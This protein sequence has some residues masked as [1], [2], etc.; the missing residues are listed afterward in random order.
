MTETEET[1]KVEVTHQRM[2]ASSINNVMREVT[3]VQKDGQVAFGKT[4]YKYA[5]E[6]G[7]LAA[8]RPAMVKHGLV[9][10]PSCEEIKESGSKVYVR[11]SY[12]LAHTSG[13]VWHEKLSMWGCGMD[14][15]DKAIYKAETGANKYML[16]KLFSIPTGDDP[17]AGKQPEEQAAKPAEKQYVM[18]DKDYVLKDIMLQFPGASDAAR[19][20]R[21]SALNAELLGINIDPVDSPDKVSKESWA[22]IASKLKG[23]K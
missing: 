7:F 20:N 8:L 6:A 3:H 23:S 12:T 16:F 19:S 2:I 18:P 13:A 22:T 15:G 17:E 5:S 14:S 10:M 1:T 11:M 4:K 21:L 9:L